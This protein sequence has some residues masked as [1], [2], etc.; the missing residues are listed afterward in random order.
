MVYDPIR[1]CD[2][3]S[4]SVSNPPLDPWRGTPGS[5]GAS[6]GYVRGS[7]GYFDRRHR[8]QS[9]VGD[10]YASGGGGYR[11]G[12]YVGAQP[13]NFSGGQSSP[14]KANRPLPR[15]AVS[16]SSMSLRELLQDEEPQPPSRR[17]STQS[18]YEEDRRGSRGASQRKSIN[19]L[20][21]DDGDVHSRPSMSP[22][23]VQSP[24]NTAALL[25]HPHV[26]NISPGSGP[27]DQPAAYL[28]TN[29]GRHSTSRSP[30]PPSHPYPINTY[31][32]PSN[33]ASTLPS[34][35][36]VMGDHVRTPVSAALEPQT[37]SSSGS[38][39]QDSSA[40]SRPM[41][42]PDTIPRQHSNEDVAPGSATRL[43]P[44]AGSL[45]LRSPSISVS[46][47]SAAQPLPAAAA[48]SSNYPLSR[49]TSSGQ[50]YTYDSPSVAHRRLSE[51]TSRPTSSSG[52]NG[53]PTSRSG[54]A[55]QL[56]IPRRESQTSVSSSSHNEPAPRSP[57]PQ[58][59]PY[60]PD[61]RVTGTTTLFDPIMP[62][63]VDRLKAEG[64]RKNPLYAWSARKMAGKPT[65][66]APSW[67]G[68]PTPGPSS[69]SANAAAGPSKSVERRDGASSKVYG[70][71]DEH[72]NGHDRENG[73]DTS[74]LSKS[75]IGS[76]RSNAEEEDA[77]VQRRR[78]DEQQ[79]FIGNAAVASHCTYTAFL[80]MR[81]RAVANVQIT[82]AKKSAWTNAKIPPSLV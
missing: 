45:P 81:A 41:L 18:V 27:Y 82:R 43:T 14:T 51:D 72:L 46:P 39:R 44:Q 9:P 53:R 11:N 5:V 63:E 20:L 19:S 30:N 29:H 10:G 64:R 47:R 50:S 75:Q 1:D 3:P 60:D 54:S 66:R 26:Y 34:E 35:Y 12:A 48:A 59:R 56:S 4:P 79:H 6:G 31:V 61:Y 23:P 74:N 15:T 33:N 17:G 40:R 25:S 28:S 57:T 69:T 2:I 80:D 70:G 21:N 62:D 16:S 71:S 52:H 42:P 36:P 73:A 37:S 24:R 13:P 8:T 76:K 49:P 68:T 58:K 7:D 77:A 78:T 65:S 55:H 32:S 22:A 67:S 38:R